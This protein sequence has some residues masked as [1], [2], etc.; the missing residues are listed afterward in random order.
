MNKNSLRS[1][2]IIG[3]LA[4]LAGIGRH[5]GNEPLIDLSRTPDDPPPSPNAFLNWLRG[6]EKR[7][8]KQHPG[9]YRGCKKNKFAHMSR[10]RLRHAAKKA[11]TEEVRGKFQLPRR[12]LR[13]IVR[14]RV[15]R[16]WMN[17]GKRT[18]SRREA[19]A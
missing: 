11:I 13:A 9:T 15:N 7:K 5:F 16:E 14:T 12:I 6:A 1:I 4:S 19:T 3:A 2:G 17:F 8:G 10:Q 18:Y